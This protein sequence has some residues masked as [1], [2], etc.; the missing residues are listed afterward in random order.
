M[1]QLASGIVTSKEE[2]LQIHQ[3][4]QRNL[5]NNIGIEERNKEG[6]VSWLYPLDLLE[7]MHAIA[8]SII[9]K[10]DKKIVGYALVALQEMIGFHRDLQILFTHLGSIQ[11][12]HRPLS[13]FSFYCMGQICV[14]KDYRG[15]GIVKKLYDEHKAVYSERFQ[16]LVTEIS[17]S[18]HRSLRAHEKIGF[19]TIYTYRDALDEWDVVVWDWS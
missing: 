13:D 19:K 5:K 11:Y 2:L 14:D 7:K 12:K 15:Q 10:E 8:P 4:N 6:F 16:I 3:L 9:V 18:N 1:D 17:T